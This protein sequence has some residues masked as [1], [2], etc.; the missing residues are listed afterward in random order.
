M[1][2]YSFLIF[3]FAVPIVSLVI[4]FC[5]GGWGTRIEPMVLAYLSAAGVYFGTV[6]LALHQTV[7]PWLLTVASVVVGVTIGTWLNNRM[8]QLPV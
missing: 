6:P 5:Q 2:L 4:T 3:F 7:L 1:G 8:P